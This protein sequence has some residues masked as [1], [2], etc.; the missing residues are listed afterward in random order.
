[1]LLFQW[2][3]R[4]LDGQNDVCVERAR[5]SRGTDMTLILLCFCVQ[6]AAQPPGYSVLGIQRVGFTDAGFANIRVGFVPYCKEG[7]LGP[8]ARPGNQLPA[9]LY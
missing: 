6:A 2:T 9:Y 4:A 7:L 8:I 1:M 3:K 5:V